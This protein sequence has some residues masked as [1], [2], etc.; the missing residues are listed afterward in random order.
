LGKSFETKHNFISEIGMK[1]ADGLPGCP[2]Q[3]EMRRRPH[4]SA[5]LVCLELGFDKPKKIRD[6]T[7]IH[8]VSI[9]RKRWRLRNVTAP[10]G[11]PRQELARP[12]RSCYNA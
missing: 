6:R 5:A 12:C 9:M 4:Q 7:A 8:R 11:G 3:I 1:S 10:P 2:H